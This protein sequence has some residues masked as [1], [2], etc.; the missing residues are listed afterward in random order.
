[1]EGNDGQ[2]SREQIRKE[3]ERGVT[4]EE[5]MTAKSKASDAYENLKIVA[6]NQSPRYAHND[7]EDGTAE[8]EFGIA[9][10]QTRPQTARGFRRVI[11]S[12]GGNINSDD[13]EI[14]IQRTRPQIAKGFRRITLNQGGNISSD[15]EFGI[16]RTR[17]QTA[18]G[19]RRV[20][21]DQGGNVSSDD[22]E[23]G[24]QRTRPQT[25]RGIQRVT[26]NQ[27]GN[28]SS[29]DDEFDIQRTRP[30]TA[31]GLRKVS[32][33]QGGNISS[34]DEFGIQRTRP[35]KPAAARPTAGGVPMSREST[36]RS[37]GTNSR[38]SQAEL[39]DMLTRESERRLMNM[40]AR[41]SEDELLNKLVREY[42]RRRSMTADPKRSQAEL[43]DF[44]AKGSARLRSTI[45][46]DSEGFLQGPV[47]EPIKAGD[48]TYRPIDYSKAPS[49][50]IG[51]RRFKKSMNS[52]DSNNNEDVSDSKAG[53][54]R[55]PLG[56]G[57]GISMSRQT[58]YRTFDSNHAEGSFDEPERE[59][60]ISMASQFEQ[61]TRSFSR[62]RRDSKLEKLDA[63]I[64]KLC[65]DIDRKTTPKQLQVEADEK[66]ARQMQDMFDSESR[67]GDEIDDET[68]FVGCSELN[69][70]KTQKEIQLENDADV[71]L[72]MQDMF[73]KELDDSDEIGYKIYSGYGLNATGTDEGQ[74]EEFLGEDYDDIDRTGSN[75]GKEVIRYNN[76]GVGAIGID[77]GKGKELMKFHEEEVEDI[78]TIN[79]KDKTSCDNDTSGFGN[80]ITRIKT[81]KPVSKFFQIGRSILSKPSKFSC[82]LDKSY[83]SDS[84]GST[85]PTQSDYDTDGS[86]TPTPSRVATPSM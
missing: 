42:A 15:D 41:R 24:M 56:L 59:L 8:E 40:N 13:D 49:T 2:A 60:G 63:N 34:D 74:M 70:E 82:G 27:S 65:A 1:M 84:E 7:E 75:K 9:R 20:T 68:L 72:R 36:R 21:L 51:P 61:P 71:A 14:G 38:R 86:I 69:R 45:D 47:K 85:T 48:S 19:F 55:S 32:L 22:D 83:G 62:H 33:N 26:L 52:V 77:K 39:V 3:L 4:E 35:T 67:A 31:R 6:E 23:F 66:L 81:K 76:K 54:S 64:A 12:Q 5:R 18:R 25:V 78:E 37:M 28:I 16:Q 80:I 11:L 29:D 17:S 57:L 46:K 50:L 58:N 53:S 43:V 79:G 73:D 30:Q 10:P 44:L